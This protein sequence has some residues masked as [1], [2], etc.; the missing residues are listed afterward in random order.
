MISVSTFDRLSAAIEE[1][2][3]QRGFIVLRKE[4]DGA[5]GSHCTE[6]GKGHF[7]YRIVWDGRESW[8]LTE[9]ANGVSRHEHGGWADLAL[10]RLGMFGS[11][12]DV[13]KYEQQIVQ[14][15]ATHL[16]AHLL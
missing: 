11:D 16:A 14:S 7:K 2:L 1:L 10:F 12:K 3:S 6:F 13:E 8:L 9:H 5:F 15:V 4:R